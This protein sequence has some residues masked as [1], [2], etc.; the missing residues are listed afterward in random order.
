MDIIAYSISAL[1]CIV[2]FYSLPHH[3]FVCLC[4]YLILMYL[5]AYLAA[6]IIQLIVVIIFDVKLS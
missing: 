6:K 2:P 1:S 4:M 3:L 5:Y